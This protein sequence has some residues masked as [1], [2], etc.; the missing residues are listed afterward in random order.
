[1]IFRDGDN[2]CKALLKHSCICKS[3]AKIVPQLINLYRSNCEY[4]IFFQQAG[5][6]EKIENSTSQ[7]GWAAE[8]I[9]QNSKLT[10]FCGGLNGAKNPFLLD[11]FSSLTTLSTSLMGLQFSLESLLESDPANT[12][13]GP[14]LSPD[15]DSLIFS[16]TIFSSIVSIFSSDKSRFLIG[17]QKGNLL[18]DV[19][20]KTVRGQIFVYLCSLLSA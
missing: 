4:W 16:S 2:F 15:M 10:N 13:L 14:L 12:S 6:V 7:N 17:L 20:N 11:F 1:M 19:D 18:K 5:T 3:F 8:D 9:N